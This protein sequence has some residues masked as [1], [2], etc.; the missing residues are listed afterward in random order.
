MPRPRLPPDPAGSC[1]YRDGD[2]ACEA[3]R[4]EPSH[5]T[6]SR[7]RPINCLQYYEQHVDSPR[8]CRVALHVAVTDGRPIATLLTACM[9]HFFKILCITL[10]FIV[11]H[12]NACMHAC[13][14]ARVQSAILGN[15]RTLLHFRCAYSS[16]YKTEEHSAIHWYWYVVH[17]R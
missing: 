8:R 12:V 9:H 6:S 5:S 4:R 7:V 15:K 17:F 11:L 16:S 13:M 1:I 10:Y 14:H 3:V 2:I